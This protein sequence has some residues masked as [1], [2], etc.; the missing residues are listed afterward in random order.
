MYLGKDNNIKIKGYFLSRLFLKTENNH[1]RLMIKPYSFSNPY[2]VRKRLSVYNPYNYSS[3]F[4]WGQ[5]AW[6]IQLK[7]STITN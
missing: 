5:A 2:V 3:Y 4:G 6:G 7:G 1:H